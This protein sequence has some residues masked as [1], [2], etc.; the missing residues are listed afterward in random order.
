M[1][2]KDALRYLDSFVDYEKIG[3]G[4]GFS[5]NLERMERL[6]GLF[7]NPE[8]TFPSIHIAGTKGKGSTAS[9]ISAILEEANFKVGLY[10]PYYTLTDFLNF[11]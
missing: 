3:A 8:R 1:N 5:F 9:F 6:A 2:E 10:T 4:A 11:I 7:G